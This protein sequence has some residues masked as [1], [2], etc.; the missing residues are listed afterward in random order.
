MNF[1]KIEKGDYIPEEISMIMEAAS[2]YIL[3][4]TGL[5]AEEAD[6]HDDLALAYL[7][8]CQDMYDN[9]AYTADNAGKNPVV[10]TILG[11]YGRNLV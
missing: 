3:S 10:E 2:G 4:Y 5:S 9:R 1:L 6:K 7:A 11:M 8:L